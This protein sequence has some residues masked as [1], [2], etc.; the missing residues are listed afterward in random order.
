MAWVARWLNEFSHC[1]VQWK[2]SSGG[3]RSQQQLAGSLCKP[4]LYSWKLS[5]HVNAFGQGQLCCFVCGGSS[6]VSIP[7]APLSLASLQ[8]HRNLAVSDPASTEEPCDVQVLSPDWCSSAQYW[9]QP[10]LIS[11]QIWMRGLSAPL[12]SLQM[13][14]SCEQVAVCLR[15]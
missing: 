10:Y 8:L 6:S 13:T 5:M 11:L 14:P 1:R 9:G 4:L 2:M 7:A 15:V 3:W 12:V